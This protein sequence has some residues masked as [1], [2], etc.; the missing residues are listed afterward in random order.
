MPELPEVETIVRQLKKKILNKTVVKFEVLD[1][2]VVDRGIEKI[3][4]FRIDKI[5]RRAKSIIFELNKDR[6]LLVHLR[7]TGHFHHAKK[8]KENELKP[9][10]KFVAAKFYLNDG[11]LLTHNSIRKFGHVKLKNKE[12]LQKE[13]SKLGLEPLDKEFTLKRFEEIL[14]K[15]KKSNVKVLLV[16]QSLIAGIGNIYAQEGLYH[17]GIDPHRKA[18]SLSQKEIEAIYRE[19]I[20]IL[21]KAIE[22][23]GTTVENYV[24]IE[25][26]GGFQK[27]LA[28][29]GKKTC[30]KRHE[31]RK[32]LIGGRGTSYCPRCQK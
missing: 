7:M 26:S 22:H 2:K 12:S 32:V 18:G 5:Y 30:K 16:D 23:H 4:P 17:A 1:S 28:V 24:H 25:G 9:Y 13:L 14:L 27:Y 3:V 31:L 21:K 6:F 10:E 29:Y 15:K 19:L 11:S 8:G 20:K